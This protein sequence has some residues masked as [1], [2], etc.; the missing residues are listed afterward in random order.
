MRE[1][2]IVPQ[3][4]AEI[5]DRYGQNDDCSDK[6]PLPIGI[7]AKEQQTIPQNFENNRTDHGSQNCALA[8]GQVRSA[9]HR[10]SNDR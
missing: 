8:A 2:L 1:A 3:K 4:L 9:D 5:V 10:S 7:N 6:D